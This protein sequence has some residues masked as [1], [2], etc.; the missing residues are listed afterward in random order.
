M[1]NKHPDIDSIQPREILKNLSSQDFLNFG[2]ED[3]AY[4]RPVTVEGASAFAIHRADGTP[5]SVAESMDAAIMSARYN[6]L[7]PL[8]VN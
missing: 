1:I 5:I 7:E 8:A 2:V 4:I 6:D 3:V